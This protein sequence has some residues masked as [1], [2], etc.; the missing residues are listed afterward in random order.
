M[1]KNKNAYLRYLIIHS[2]LKRNKYKQGYPK[3][4]DLLWVLNDQGYDVSGS[5]LEKDLNFLKNERGAPLEYNRYQKCYRYT[6]DW[7]FDIPLSPEDVRILHMLIHKLE[8]FGDAQEFKM[9]KDSI[10][11]LSDHFNL[12][13]QHPDYKIDKY[14]LFEYTKGFSGKHLL[15][16]IYDAIF[17][18]KEIKF[19][20]CRFESDRPTERT[21]Q[22]YILK[23]HRNRWYVIGKEYEEPRIFGLDR[24]YNLIVS[25][26]YFIQ[27]PD[28]YDEIFKVLRDAVGVM[29]FGFESEDVILH[30]D[31]SEAKYIKSLLLHRSQEVIQEDK[32]GITI[33]LHVKITWEFI[34]DCILRFGDTVKVLKPQSLA[35]KVSEI[36]QNAIDSY[37][38]E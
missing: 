30:F 35:N 27:D 5:T 19:T 24:I 20:H 18:K 21:I 12:M 31:S 15:S 8:I 14:I 11:R 9:V 32:D 7:E 2:Q 6:E 28:F 33:S 17:E 37:N 29:A 36:Y 34:M 1:P 3:K 10:D 22:P 25:D 16:P 23:E 13:Q 26:R 38:R 4:E